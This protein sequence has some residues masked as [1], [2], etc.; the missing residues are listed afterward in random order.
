MNLNNYHLGRMQK[1]IF[2][3]YPPPYAE[4]SLQGLYLDHHLYDLGSVQR[5]FV[6]A[7]F[8]A[9]LDGR[10]ALEDIYTGQTYLPK[11]LTT[12]ADFRLFLELEAQADCLITHGGYL[13]ALADGRLGNILQIGAHPSGEDLVEWRRSHGLAPQPALAIASASLDFVI[14]TLVREHDQPVTIFTGECADPVKVEAWRKE[15]YQV[16]FAGRGTMV[17]GQKLIPILGHL[18]Y[19]SIYLI[20][21]PSMLDTVVRCGWL[22]RLYQTTTHQLMGGEAFRTMVPGPE[23]GPAGHLC[24]RTL[25][26]DPNGPGGTGQW[27]SRFDIQ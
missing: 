20:A 23:L 25:Y 14:P 13:R 18:G 9:S 17:E 26:F 22:N 4:V 27:F 15:G 1:Q 16:M 3:L 19:R 8:L 12:P 21:G 10:I 5:P 7:N 2:R 24:L 6:Y 11:S